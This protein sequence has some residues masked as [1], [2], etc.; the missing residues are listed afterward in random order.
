MEL[1][2]PKEKK[3]TKA[4]VNWLLRQLE[5]SDPTEIY[6][7]AKWPGRAADTQTSLAEL[8][9]DPLALD[10]EN[11][12]S[13]PTRFEVLLVRDLAGRF[14]GSRTFIEELEKAV[15]QF[16]EQVGERLRAWVPYPPKIKKADAMKKGEM[17]EQQS[18]TRSDGND[19][20][21]T[22]VPQSIVGDAS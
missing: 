12:K 7:K 11:A 2:A 3:T 18:G 14:S 5:K 9:E 16:Y 8:R 19:V 13:T 22:A 17:T 1:D 10:G 6:I 15:P 21:N 20:E 4:R